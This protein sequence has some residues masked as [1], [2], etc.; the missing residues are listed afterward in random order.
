MGG[1]GIQ[2][3]V[4]GFFVYVAAIFHR[5]M[6]RHPTDRVQ[7][8][9]WLPWQ[10]HLCVLYGT[11]AIILVRSVFRLIEYAQGNGG[12]LLRTEAWLYVF[13]AALMMLVMLWFAVVHPSEIYALLKGQKGKA[14]RW[15]YKVYEVSLLNGRRRLSSEVELADEIS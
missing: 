10:K 12:Y 8:D 1:L 13:D 7:N 2:I 9:P 14:V 6:L 4:F 3:I 15:G 5:R 11:S